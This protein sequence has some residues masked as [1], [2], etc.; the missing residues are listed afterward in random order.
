MVNHGQQRLTALATALTAMKVFDNR[1]RK[2][3]VIISF[4]TIEEK[5]DVANAAIQKSSA[6]IYD[7]S[8][9]FEPD[10]STFEFVNKY[11]EKNDG[12]DP[13]IVRFF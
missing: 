12:V 3:R 4:N 7:I 9:I 6:W 11:I 5:F 1:Y 8:K 13:N 2:G 10:F